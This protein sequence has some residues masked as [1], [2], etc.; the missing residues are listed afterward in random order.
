[1]FC[2]ECNREVPDQE[3]INAYME[4][5]RTAFCPGCG[6]YYIANKETRWQFIPLFVNRDLIIR[7]DVEFAV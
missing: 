4:K 5:I 3:R 7:E 2:H 6:T 1:M